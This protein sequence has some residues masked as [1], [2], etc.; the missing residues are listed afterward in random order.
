MARIVFDHGLNETE[1]TK[2]S[3]CE[4]GY[5][6]KLELDS[7][8]LAPREPIDLKGSV[9][10]GGS[11]NGLMQLVTTGD[12][13]T[14]LVYGAGSV[15]TPA[16]YSWTGSNTSTA[17]TSVR[18]TNLDSDSTL[19]GVFWALDDYLT[20]VDIQ[21]LTPILNWNGTTLSR[22]KTNLGAGTA[23]TNT[24]A[25]LQTNG[26]FSEAADSSATGTGTTG[27]SWA[28]SGWAT[29]GSLIT[30]QVD[31]EVLTSDVTATAGRD[32][33]VTYTIGT[34][35]LASITVGGTA[36][37]DVTVGT[38]SETVTAASAS[39]LFVATAAATHGSATLDDITIYVNAIEETGS[40][41]YTVLTPSNGYAI[42]DTVII[43]GSDNANLNGE[44]EVATLPDS[45]SWT[46]T[47]TAGYGGSSA[48][49]GTSEKT[50]ELFAKY[51]V[52]HNNRLWLFNIKTDADDN[53]HMIIAS[54]FEDPESFDT[55]NR[56]GVASGN[57]AFYTLTPDLKAINGVAQINKQLI[58]STVDGALHRLTGIDAADYKFTTYY[59][60]SH[61]IGDESIANIGNDITFMKKGGNIDLL[62]ATD[63]SGDV[64]AD[65]I[66]RWLPDSTKD[67]TYAD[68]V[69]DQ[70]GQRVFYF[71]GNKVL[72]LFKDI[73]A[74]GGGSPWGM[75]KTALT[76]ASDSSSIFDS[77][78]ILYMRRPQETTLTVYFGDKDGNIY[79]LI[80]SGTGDNS[81][82]IVVS[83][84][85]ALIESSRENILQGYVHYRRLAAINISLIFDWANEY[86]ET[87]SDIT[88]KGPPAS[89]ADPTYY[90][91][92]YY[93]NE[94]DNF[95]NEGFAFAEKKS[96][97]N[98]APAG[99][100]EGFNMEFYTETTQ[101]F[102]IDYIALME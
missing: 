35:A 29:N 60:G 98:F 44:H 94:T 101:Q 79:D 64:R 90:G 80:G 54:Q 20:I 95:Y 13:E 87:Q 75:Y 34:A 89:Q 59:A 45:D 67:L 22:H 3:E 72:V 37:A 47:D 97:Q 96:R 15:T 63:T 57:A 10:N 4:S 70:H 86:N 77:N 41:V 27:W 73:L 43:A 68:I 71:I 26:T 19:R 31:S 50:V 16:I 39:S 74:T 88:L 78:A 84:R 24:S 30:T 55:V 92:G 62:S 18:T 42:G 28:N 91:G 9:P 69:Y 56:S 53:P 8:H 12:T 40:G 14:T 100:S 51:G 83:R 38:H 61:A 7:R 2:P 11:V 66:S 49:H 21:K 5:N 93:Y 99:R 102:Q 23:L 32:Y 17:F 65:D 81:S 1:S 33:T 76:N 85:T 48:T 25:Q 46:F 36:L 58:I 52:V 6:F 82:N